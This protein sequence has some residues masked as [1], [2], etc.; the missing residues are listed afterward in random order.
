MVNGINVNR[1]LENSKRC[2]VK[3]YN[4]YTSGI[5]SF[6][7]QPV[8]MKKWDEP[9][10]GLAGCIAIGHQLD[11]KDVLIPK[12]S[13]NGEH[14]SFDSVRNRWTP[15]YMETYYRSKPTGDYAKSGLLCVKETKCFAENDAFV[16]ELTLFNDDTSPAK[17]SLELSM[18]FE[19]ISDSTYSVEAGIVPASLYKE[20]T[21]RGF[22]AAKTSPGF[23]GEFEIGAN[24]KVTFRYGFAFSTESADEAET[25]LD[26][27]LAKADVFEDA[28]NRFNSWMDDNIPRLHTANADLLKVYYYRAFVIKCSIH[29]PSD[30]LPDSDFEGECVYESPFGSWF[31]APVGLPVP[32]HI[33]EMKWM[34][35]TDALLSDIGNW[36][37]GVGC[38]KDY[39]QYTPMAIWNLYRKAGDVSII[40]SAFDACREYTL[41]KSPDG[42]LPQTVGSGVTGAEYQPS[43]YQHTDPAWDWRN[44]NIYN[45]NSKYG[46]PVSKLYRV[47]ECSMYAAN[48]RACEKMAEVLGCEDDKKLFEGL[49]DKVTEKILS[50]FWNEEKQFFFDVDAATGKQCDMAY[51]YDG[52]APMMLGLAG[53]EYYG[54]FDKL[55]E[56][57]IFDGNFSVTSVDKN[58]PMYWFDNCIVGPTAASKADAHEY[59]C[60]WNGPMWPYA[61]TMVLNSLG[62]SAREDESLRDTWNRL[63]CGYTELHFDGGDRSTP[64]ICEHY[65]P[66][67]GVSFSP[68]TEY[69]HSEWLSLFMSYWAGINI[70]ADKITFSPYTKEEFVIEGVS[71][72]KK[73]YRFS[74]TAENG[75]EFRE[76]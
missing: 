14:Q 42:E 50:L 53:K 74:Q 39:I 17:V 29:T 64:V 2:D 75:A 70:S 27:A 60:S 65:R 72:G 67:D 5:G 1:L 76:M 41:R 37:R 11:V 47:D 26:S 9:S 33:D 23:C 36:C 46:L 12:I 10:L 59:D 20:M 34:N 55:S 73:K 68:Y 35:K 45:I 22:A 4:I 18:P 24:S 31:G 48:L 57:G 21:L 38:T 44:D 7:R 52:F 62:N 61:V 8:H 66:T 54:A 32:L 43:F 58:C 51:S 63:F 71:I 6:E 19:K 56:N 16:S 49:A 15:A 30:V 40:R 3:G 69:F 28:E 25:A 13:L